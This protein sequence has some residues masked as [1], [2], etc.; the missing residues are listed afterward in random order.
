MA[1]K[2]IVEGRRSGKTTKAIKQ[3]GRTWKYILVPN[4][5]M[6][7]LIFNQAMEMGVDIPYPITIDEWARGGVDSRVKREGVI[8]DEGLM[9]LEQMLGTHI[10]MI[11]MSERED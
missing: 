5:A 2:I 7:K 10:H 4:R 1:T 9:M 6:A 11:T 8:V 3:S